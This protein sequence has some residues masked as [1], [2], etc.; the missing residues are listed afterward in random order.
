MTRHEDRKREKSNMPDIV[1]WGDR[2]NDDTISRSEEFDG[3]TCFM[4]RSF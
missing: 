3:G 1:N 2:E 4:E